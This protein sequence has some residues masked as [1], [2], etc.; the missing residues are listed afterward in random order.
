MGLCC[1]KQLTIEEKQDRCNEIH[2]NIFALEQ[3]TLTYC[4]G[5][6]PNEH[7][8]DL[9]IAKQIAKYYQSF[10]PIYNQFVA[11]EVINFE[12]LQIKLKKHIHEY[13]ELFPDNFIDP[14]QFTMELS[15]NLFNSLKTYQMVICNV[16]L[17]RN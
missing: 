10:F 11:L 14:N 6:S 2:G 7:V 17:M 3:L 12:N 9:Q 4:N 1:T 5:F 16:G 8:V 15:K 13:N